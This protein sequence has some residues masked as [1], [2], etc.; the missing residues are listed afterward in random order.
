MAEG[1]GGEVRMRG[2]M[3]VWRIFARDEWLVV[4]W[5]TLA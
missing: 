2:C 3:G 4:L 1:G 5:L